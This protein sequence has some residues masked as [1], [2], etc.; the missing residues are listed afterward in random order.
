MKV[1]LKSEFIEEYLARKHLSQNIFAKKVGT[2][3]GYISQLM[4]AERNPSPEMRKKIQTALN[5]YDF[6][7]LFRIKK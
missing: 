1:Q 6:E 3:S 4:S 2:T 7:K 5:E